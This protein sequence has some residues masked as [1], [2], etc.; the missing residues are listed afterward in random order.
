VRNTEHFYFQVCASSD[1]VQDEPSRREVVD[2]LVR[3]AVTARLGHVP[4]GR[5][6]ELDELEWIEDSVDEAEGETQARVRAVVVWD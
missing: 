5:E 4:P 6:Y 1:L 2:D 3:E